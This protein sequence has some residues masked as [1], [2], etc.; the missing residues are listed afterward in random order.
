[1]YY[2]ITYISCCVD[3]GR[4]NIIEPFKRHFSSYETGYRI[5]LDTHLPL[6]SYNSVPDFFIPSH[7]D[8]NNFINKHLDKKILMDILIENKLF[9]SV[10]DREDTYKN[11]IVGLIKEY[12]P[13]VL[14][15][16]FMMQEVIE[17]NPF[18]S[19]YFVW[20][21]CQ[22]NSGIEL[23]LKVEKNCNLFTNQLTRLIKDKFLIFKYESSSIESCWKMNVSKFLSHN[24]RTQLNTNMYGCFW[25]ASKNILLK[26]FTSYWD[27]YKKLLEDNV[28]PTEEL[29]LNILSMEHKDYFNS[30]NIGCGNYKEKMYKLIMNS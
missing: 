24:N 22:F 15:K 13:L 27:I 4:G 6:V 10:Y 16:M 30:F 2:P 8:N 18:N 20:I 7:R 9:N 21:D 29:I 19:E 11:G 23:D 17:N 12:S 1:V 28:I 26:L 14:M 3:I 5:N 25:G